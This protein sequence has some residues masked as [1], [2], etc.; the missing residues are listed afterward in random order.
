MA[1]QSA[2][3]LIVDD[4]PAVCMFATEALRRDGYDVAFAW[5]I[6]E[7]LSLLQAGECFDAAVVDVIMPGMS[8][9]EFAKRFKEFLPDA[10]VLFFTGNRSALSRLRPTLESN[11][12][13]LDKPA[14]AAE[15]RQALSHLLRRS[16]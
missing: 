16:Q 12:A 14:T 3:I 15:L 7:A 9:D 13:A 2:R 11:E 5:R 4:E 1:A 10:K 6:D 8:G